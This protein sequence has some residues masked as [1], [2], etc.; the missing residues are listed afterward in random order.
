VALS[1]G[2]KTTEMTTDR[3]FGLTVGP[4]LYWWP[5][6]EMLA[7][8]ADVADG[9]ADTVVLGELVCSRRNEFRLDDWLA[10][11]R[12]LRAAGKR[13]VLATMALVTSEAELRGVR[14]LVEQ[15]EF[16]VEAGDVSALAMLARAHAADQ[17]R[18]PFW[19]GPH[20]N[21]YSRPA[22]AQWAALGA[23]TWVP[24][25]ELSVDAIGRVN[26]PDDPVPGAAGPVATEVF[27]FGRMPLAFSAR[28]FTARHHRLRKDECDFRCR[29]DADGL[30]LHT[31]DGRPFLVLNGIQT[32]SAA[33]QCLIGGRDALAGAG[34]RRLRLAPTSRGFARALALFDGVFNHDAD[35]AAAHTELAALGLPGTLVDGFAHRR[36]GIEELR[37]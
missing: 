31:E 2:R 21:A 6:A 5:R 23:G 10:L 4:L 12:E 33:L 36:A 15:G 14:R 9:P 22:L 29:D 13:V 11:A 3:R 28:C 30:P 32:Q 20:V 17:A 16:A 1:T 26:P 8:Y 35:A 34:V 18:P 7:F 24:P 27:A 25:L 19:I 37:S